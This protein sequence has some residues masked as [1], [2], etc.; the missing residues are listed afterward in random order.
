MEILSLG[1]KIKRKRKELN[2]TLKDLAK[3]RITPGQISLIESGRSNPSMDLLEYLAQ[4]LN[5]TIEYL[6]ESEESQA[7]NI[8]TYYERMIEAY[9]LDEDFVKAEQFIE[10]VLN[11][12]NT[13]NLECKKAKMLYLKGD[14]YAREGEFNLAKQSLLSANII[15]IEKNKNKEIIETFLNLAKITLKLKSYFSASSYLKQAEKVFIDNEISEEYLLGEIYFYLAK[16]YFGMENIGQAM[17]Y[18]TL[19]KERFEKI[20][21]KEKY[22]KELLKLSEEYDKNGDLE[23]ALRYSKKTLGIYKELENFEDMADIENDL[24]ILFYNFENIEESFKHYEI[25][26][27]MR[28]EN[29]N[30]KLVQ[31][32]INICKNYLKIKDIDKCKQVLNEIS[33]KI[34]DEDIQEKIECNIIMYRIYVICDNKLDAEKILLETYRYAKN[35]GFF[36]KA[37]RIAIMIAKFYSDEREE[38][39]AKEYLDEGVN[40]LKEFG[41]LNID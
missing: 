26:K 33:G 1:E 12:S 9:I 41:I 16:A 25:A 17:S 31:T 18:A 23:N 28:V 24:G 5:T 27:K 13:Y 36:D 22:A 3:D 30:K 8:C 14:M 32:L 29:D 35:R 20:N 40:I 6:M 21:N 38:K 37:G 11:Y 2:M 7:K 19:A 34:T 39:K 15:F 10:K 4:N